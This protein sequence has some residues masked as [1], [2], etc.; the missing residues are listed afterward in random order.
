MLASSASVEADGSAK[1]SPAMMARAKA[2]LECRVASFDR[3]EG[4]W[5]LVPPMRILW[6][7]KRSALMR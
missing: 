1:K 2:F 5:P 7:G 6:R 3:T 4:N